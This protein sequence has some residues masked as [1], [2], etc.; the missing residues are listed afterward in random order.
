M[1]S[2]QYMLIVRLILVPEKRIY[3]CKAVS[4]VGTIKCLYEPYN[5][6]QGYYMGAK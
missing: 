6:L 1:Y 3:Q 4:V 5:V 2:V